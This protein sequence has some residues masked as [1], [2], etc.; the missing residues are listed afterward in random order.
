MSTAKVNDCRLQDEEGGRG[1]QTGE[2]K[3]IRGLQRSKVVEEQCAKTLMG[4]DKVQDMTMNR[5]D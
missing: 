3:V 5:G 2:W 4:G 1:L